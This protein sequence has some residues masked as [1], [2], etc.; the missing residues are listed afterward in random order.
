[1]L[2]TPIM[3]NHFPSAPEPPSPENPRPI[4][5]LPLPDLAARCACETHKFLAHQAA[6]NA[7]CFDLFRRAIG[8]QDDDAWTCIYQHYAPL[9]HTWVTQHPGAPAILD[10]EGRASLINAAFAKFAQ[11][12]TPAKLAQFDSVACLLRYLKLCTASVVADEVR[13]HQTRWREEPLELVEQ[14]PTTDDPADSLVDAMSAQGLWQIVWKELK[15]DDERVLA[16]LAFLHGLKPGEI[17]RL[18]RQ[19]FPTADD[20]C[21]VKRNIVQRLRGSRRLRQMQRLDR[22]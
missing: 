2:K 12:L 4:E 6:N 5:T 1:M 13:S 20:A 17:S 3:T 14:E 22:L 15:N 11:A 21:R 19:Q 16:E 7:Y 9:V 8:E 10:Q 18:H